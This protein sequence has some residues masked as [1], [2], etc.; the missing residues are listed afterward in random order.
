MKFT[1]SRNG[2]T[3]LTEEIELHSFCS[4][5]GVAAEI[6]I[7]QPQTPSLELNTRSSTDSAAVT[8]P[9]IHHGLT[10]LLSI[11]GGSCF[12]SCWKSNDSTVPLTE[13]ILNGWLGSFLFALTINMCLASSVGRA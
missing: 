3:L 2:S 1:R 10:H 7:N 4:R 8:T 5:D 9:D 13:E 11:C 12:M 6:P